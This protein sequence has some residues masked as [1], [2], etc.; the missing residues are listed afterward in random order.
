M[1]DIQENPN[2][3]VLEV[4]VIEKLSTA[5]FDH[6]EPVLRKHIRESIRPRLLLKMEEFSGWDDASAFWKDLKVDTEFIGD[7]KRIALVGDARWEEWSAKLLNPVTATEIKFFKP[8]KI[9]HARKWLNK[10]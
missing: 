2:S 4:K 6:L 9:E 7:F 1:I 8:E 5:D 10:E 3:D